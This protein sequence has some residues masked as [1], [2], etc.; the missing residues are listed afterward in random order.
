MA[1]LSTIGAIAL[2]VGAATTAGA[3]IYGAK[4]AG[5]AQEQQEKL[6][7]EQQEKQDQLIKEAE[8]KAKQEQ[9][10]EEAIAERTAKRSAQKKRA[11][12]SSGISSTFLTSPLGLTGTAGYSGKTFLGE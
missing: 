7:K 12:Q 11:A 8:A 5:E 4:K 2:G 3:T 10:N 9:V 1:A 6:I